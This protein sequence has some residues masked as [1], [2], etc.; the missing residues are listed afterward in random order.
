MKKLIVLLFSFLCIGCIPSSEMQT[1]KKIMTETPVCW[2]EVHL[3][4][5]MKFVSY[6]KH[7]YGFLTIRKGNDIYVLYEL[8]QVCKMHIIEHPGE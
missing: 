5:D 8:T 7:P 3:E 1:V 6:N 4:K 2:E